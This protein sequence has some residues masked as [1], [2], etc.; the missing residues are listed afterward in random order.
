MPHLSPPFRALKQSLRDIPGVQSLL[1]WFLLQLVKPGSL[2]LTTPAER[3]YYFHIAS[4][5]VQG[6]GAVID[7][8]S[9]LGSTTV[10]L[11]RGLA[12]NPSAS[13]RS[14]MVDTYD[15]FTWPSEY[16][17]FAPRGF[18]FSDGES[19]LP[20]FRANVRPWL[21]QIRIHEGDLTK[22]TWAGPVELIINDAA[23][24]W[25]LSGNIWRQFVAQLV[26]G[27][28]LIEQD[29][30]HYYCPW[31]HLVHYRFRRHFT[32]DRDVSGGAT[33]AFRLTET[34]AR[35]DLHS[36]FEPTGYS[37]DECKEA[38]EWSS[39]LVDPVWH[40]VIHAAHAMHYVHLGDAEPARHVFEQIAHAERH[41]PDVRLTEE[42]LR[43]LENR[44]AS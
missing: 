26:E 18:R 29:F 33:T 40:P 44:D 19:F 39:R 11:A 20:L 23:K 24:S 2:G 21:K 7:L 27:G 8:G 5:C 35:N 41:H 4:N 12:A 22:A 25:A 9:W 37:A 17:P 13:A 6:R 1:N 16:D 3:E 32:L 14:T 30:K 34:I 38:F 15:L 43:D 36:A 10:S 42:R 31:L 28:F